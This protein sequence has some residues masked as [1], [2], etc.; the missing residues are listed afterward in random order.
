MNLF[1]R[2]WKKSYLLSV[3]LWEFTCLMTVL[4]KLFNK[5]TFV[6]WK[7]NH[8]RYKEKIRF[9]LV[10]LCEKVLNVSVGFFPLNLML[11]NVAGCIGDW[12]LYFTKEQ[13]IVVTCLENAIFQDQH[14][15]IMNTFTGYKSKSK[16]CANTHHQSYRY[17]M[18]IIGICISVVYL[19][20]MLM[21]IY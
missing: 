12:K 3:I 17:S 20:F 18:E 21:V 9:L 16:I 13:E 4:R 7:W 5:A 2:I 10:I 19:C 6:R 15:L 8:E 1:D 11:K 14:D